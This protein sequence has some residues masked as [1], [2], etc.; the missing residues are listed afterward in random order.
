[1]FCL[2]SSLACLSETLSFKSLKTLLCGTENSFISQ[3]TL[4][5]YK[6]KCGGKENIVFDEI[7]QSYQGKKCYR[8]IM[9]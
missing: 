8:Q 1:L 6:N 7:I 3:A 9:L 2:T 4:F 5:R